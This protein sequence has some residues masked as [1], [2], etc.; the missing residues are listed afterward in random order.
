LLQLLLLL[1]V[2]FHQLLCLLLMPLLDLLLSAFIRMLSC[3]LLV[4]LF[5]LLL[6]T[7]SFFVLLRE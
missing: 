2:F 7:L 4:L 1:G 3:E 6:K 5:L